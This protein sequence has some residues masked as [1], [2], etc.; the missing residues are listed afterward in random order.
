MSR[1]D[2]EAEIGSHPDRPC[3]D[4]RS[5]RCLSIIEFFFSDLLADR[6]DDPSPSDGRPESESG[7]DEYNNPPWSILSRISRESS[8]E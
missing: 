6:D 4:K 7:R 5:G 1:T 2:R 3:R 8:D